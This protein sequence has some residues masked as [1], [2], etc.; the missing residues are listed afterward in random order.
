MRIFSIALLVTL[1]V[2]TNSFGQSKARP[3]DYSYYLELLGS[4]KDVLYDSIINQ[5]DQ[6]IT[7]NPW[8]FKVSIE[9]CRLIENAY[10]DSYEDY[11]PNYDDAVA[12]VDTLVATFPDE[13][14]ALLLKVDYLYGEDRTAYLKELNDDIPVNDKWEPHA[15]KVYRLLAEAYEDESNYELAIRFA[16]VAKERK[17]SLD[18]TLMLGRLYKAQSKNK[19][20]IEVLSSSLDSLDESWELNQK[21]RLL[22]ELGAPEKAIEAFRLAKKD[23]TGWQDNSAL[24]QA[25]IDNGLY[26]EAREYLAK[27]VAASTWRKEGSLRKLFEYDLNHGS[28]DS[29]KVEYRELVELNFMTDPIGIDRIRIFFKAPLFYWTVDDILHLLLLFLILFLMLVIPYLWI[30]PIHYIGTYFRTKGMRLSASAFR[31]GLRHFW[32]ICSGYLI[33]SFVALAIVDYP[34]IISMFDESIVYRDALP[35]ISKVNATLVLLF[36]SG[37]L[38]MTIFL[39]KRTDLRLIWGT[40]QSKGR[41]I[42]VGIGMALLL[43]SGLGIYAAILRFAG[44]SLFENSAL[45]MLSIT[46]DIIAVNQFYHPALGFLIVVILVPIYEEILFRGVFLS[47]CEKHMKF[48]I[49][50]SLQAFVFALVHQELKLIPFYFAFAIVC[51]HYRNKTQS[52]ATGISI[53]VTN[54]LLAFIGILILQARMG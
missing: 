42:G 12:C 31:W 38:V 41:A 51:G 13:P 39:L 10:Y 36:C 50:N 47:A 19:L 9:R 2:S 52:L 40:L 18:L 25:F 44:I 28:L 32:I 7:Q 16:T 24:A 48:W 11:N 21:G 8:D 29:A 20:A 49:A 54:N 3:N 6:Y 34:T 27:E 5:F 33:I 53:H 43:K 45:G 4:S 17:D 26:A 22:L 1:T 35:E 46:D 23:S 37:L 15:W 30:L 14:E